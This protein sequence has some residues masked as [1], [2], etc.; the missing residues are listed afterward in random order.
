MTGLD[1]YCEWAHKQADRV[2]RVIK[3]TLIAGGITWIIGCTPKPME[4]VTAPI[5]AFGVAQCDGEIALYVVVDS[6]HVL[7]F[8]P[9]QTT[10]F[11]VEAD[12]KVSESHTAPT[13]FKS[14]MDLAKSAGITSNVV[15]PCNQSGT[16]T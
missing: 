15:A 6:T 1:A 16:S 5:A 8:D 14:A 4:V 7:R 13:P 3:C 10:I 12:G 9:K 2:S 11:A